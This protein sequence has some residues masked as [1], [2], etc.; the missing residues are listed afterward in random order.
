MVSQPRSKQSQLKHRQQFWNRTYKECVTIGESSSRSG[1][2]L[3]A[4]RSN[5]ASQVDMCV[6][7][8]LPAACRYGEA[9]MPFCWC[10][11]IGVCWPKCPSLARHLDRCKAQICH[12]SS[13]QFLKTTGC[14]SDVLPVCKQP[15]DLCV[16]L[17]IL[18]TCPPTILLLTV[19]L[20]HACMQFPKTQCHV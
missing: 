15:Q 9:M 16:Y 17:F 13:G 12:H 14:V 2:N 19:T 10:R 4:D 5:V 8:H 11:Q 6:S 1:Y 18:C 20:T 3:S 7:F